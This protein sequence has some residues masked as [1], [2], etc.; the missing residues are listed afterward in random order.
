MKAKRD[1][2]ADDD[3]EDHLQRV[4]A[5]MKENKPYANYNISPW[6]DKVC[7]LLRIRIRMI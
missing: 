2:S 1:K 4:F 7:D 5:A 3:Q 6:R